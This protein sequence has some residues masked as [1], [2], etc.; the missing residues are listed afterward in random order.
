MKIKIFLSILTI[1]SFTF[2][3]SQNLKIKYYKKYT[4]HQVF[5]SLKYFYYDYYGIFDTV[6][7][8]MFKKDNDSIIIEDVIFDNLYP[9]K[10]FLL[11]IP[12][13]KYV[14]DNPDLYK[15]SIYLFIKDKKIDWNYKHDLL[16]LLQR[17]CFKDILKLVS[18]TFEA[19]KE[20][21]SLDL[22]TKWFNDSFK[23]HQFVFVSL[24]EQFNLSLEIK[25]NINIDFEKK[26]EE[27]YDYFTH[28]YGYK[29]HYSKYFN[30]KLY[31][32]TR[33]IDYKFYELSKNIKYYFKS[34]CF[35]KKR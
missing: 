24:I 8:V 34:K 18:L 3:F 16:V 7:N 33:R 6:S 2:A 14:F 10:Y 9:H 27:I 11:N 4:C 5:D 21:D 12:I 22:N 19:V 20:Y 30:Y 28:K 15:D 1:T 23:I 31:S 35:E 17:L 26:L 13:F 32:Y 25:K 29:Y